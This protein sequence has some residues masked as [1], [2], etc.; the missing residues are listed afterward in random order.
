VEALEA[1]AGGDGGCDRCR[2]TLVIVENAISGEFHSATWNGE[3]LDRAELEERHAETTCP[4]CGRRIDPDE[5]VEIRVGG[6]RRGY[7]LSK[8]N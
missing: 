1:A 7:P 4:K 6:R 2:G 3:P 5:G 8:A